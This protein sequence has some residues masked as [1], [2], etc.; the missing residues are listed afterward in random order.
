MLYMWRFAA[1]QTAASASGC[2]GVLSQA[3]ALVCSR[4]QPALMAFTDLSQSLLNT[5]AGQ[6]AS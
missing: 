4:M 1:Q 5:Y 6:G 2:N 3:P